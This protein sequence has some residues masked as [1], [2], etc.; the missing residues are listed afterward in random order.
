MTSEDLLTVIE[1]K[2]AIHFAGR[3]LRLQVG[4]AELAKP[5]AKDPQVPVL[6][7]QRQHRDARDDNRPAGLHRIELEGWL[8]GALV[9]LHVVV[10]DVVERA[11][12]GRECLGRAI[13]RQRAPLPH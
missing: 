1:E 10:E 7:G 11:P 9:G 8:G 6:E 5:V 2:R 3:R 4:L 13:Q 12:E